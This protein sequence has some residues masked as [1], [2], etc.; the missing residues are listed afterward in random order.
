MVKKPPHNVE[1]YDNKDSIPVQE[2]SI[3]DLN[4]DGGVKPHIRIRK[5][6]DIDDEVTQIYV[7]IASEVGKLKP[8]EEY[9]CPSIEDALKLSCSLSKEYDIPILLD[10]I[11]FNE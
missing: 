7:Q 11:S 3:D 6:V 9:E 2:E 8:D 10:N 1:Y 5:F 4:I